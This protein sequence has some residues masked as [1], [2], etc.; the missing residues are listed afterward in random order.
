MD[1][2]IMIGMSSFVC[3]ATAAGFYGMLLILPLNDTDN[4]DKE[5]AKCIGAL[6]ALYFRK[7]LLY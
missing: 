6:I 7:G 1:L 5:C 4:E 3:D 2:K